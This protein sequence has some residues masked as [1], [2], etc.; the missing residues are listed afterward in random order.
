MCNSWK[1]SHVTLAETVFFP[2]LI[3]PLFSFVPSWIFSL[4]PSAAPSF[5]SS[6]STVSIPSCR[7]WQ[8]PAASGSSRGPATA[9][10][11]RPL[12]RR[13]AVL[14][15]HGKTP[16]RTMSWPCGGRD[17]LA[18]PLKGAKTRALQQQRPEY[19]SLHSADTN[20][21]TH[22]MFVCKADFGLYK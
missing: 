4:P 13:G 7:C 17:R 10:V 9:R 16:G 14:W 6:S 12:T 19:L 8:H 15:C 18:L 20:R 11:T 21:V 2:Q 22:V 5:S 1:S 3:T